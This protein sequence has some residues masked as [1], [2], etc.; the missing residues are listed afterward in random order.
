[1]TCIVGIEHDSKVYIGADAAGSNGYGIEI[2]VEPKVFR[3]GDFVIGYT[4]S[5]RMGNLLQHVLKAPT[6]E[7]ADDQDSVHSF[8][9]RRFIPAVRECLADGGWL[10]SKDERKSGGVFL[11]GFRGELYGVGSDLQVGR[12]ADGYMA[13]GSGED[14][15]LGSLHTTMP[16]AGFEHRFDTE[17]TIR[18]RITSALL[19][20][21]HH[22]CGVAGPFTIEV[23]S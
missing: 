9:V 16:K 23:T 18:D 14:L 5:F 8:M 1:M 4:T 3:R 22:A 20:A 17:E 19:A 10:A 21:E 6:W 12:S 2:R 15:A 11:V 7:V 13:C